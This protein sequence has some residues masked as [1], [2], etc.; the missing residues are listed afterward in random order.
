M[1]PLFLILGLILSRILNF[2][3]RKHSYVGGTGGQG[4]VCVQTLAWF[5]FSLVIPYCFLFCSPS[6]RVKVT[7]FKAEKSR[8]FDLDETRVVSNVST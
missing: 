2:I 8:F 7:I 1:C 5:L 6:W 4:A 3:V